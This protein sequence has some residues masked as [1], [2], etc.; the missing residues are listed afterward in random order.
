MTTAPPSWRRRAALAGGLALAAGWVIG[1]PRLFSGSSALSFRDLPRL[2]GFRALD[3]AGAVSA[4][5]QSAFIG[6]DAAPQA[7]NRVTQREALRAT[8][9]AALFGDWPKGGAV[10]LAY[11]TDYNCPNCRVFETRLAN[12]EAGNAG[13]IRII[14]HEF[15]LLGPPSV[16]AARAVL[17]AEM[18]GRYDAMHARL[19]STR[20]VSDR[21][22]MGAIAED[23]GLDAARL[24]RDMDAPEVD[25]HLARS[26]ALADLFGFYG[27]P[28][29]VLGRTAFMG[30]IPEATFVALVEEEASLSPLDCD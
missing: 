13:A 21:A 7:S 23:V 25:R 18:Q 29:A 19:I 2:P 11:F 20:L 26:K 24:L 15:P 1:A 10:P 17:A 14:R 5:A 27:T 16:T 4:G 6:I 22:L 28:G 9:C 8:P 3:A 30:A 12:F